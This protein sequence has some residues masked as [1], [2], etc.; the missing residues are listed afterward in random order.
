VTLV[1]SGIAN[2]AVVQRRL[3]VR[4]SHPTKSFGFTKATFGT[5]RLRPQTVPGKIARICC[6]Q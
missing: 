4:I 3:G 2:A 5:T 1:Q 6:R